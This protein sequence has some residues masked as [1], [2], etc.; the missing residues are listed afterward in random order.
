MPKF[1]SF[2]CHINILRTPNAFIFRSKS[3]IIAGYIF[4]LF[5]LVFQLR[6]VLYF[7][8]YAI[9]LFQFSVH[10][11]ENLLLKGLYKKTIVKL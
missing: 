7:E 11:P 2:Q 6:S 4:T 10:F 1:Q 8:K 3:I 9:I 5:E